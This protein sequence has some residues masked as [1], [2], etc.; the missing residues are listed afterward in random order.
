MNPKPSFETKFEYQIDGNK[1][2][3]SIN[4]ECDQSSSSEKITELN[5]RFINIQNKTLNDLQEKLIGIPITVTCS[6]MQTLPIHDENVGTLAENVNPEIVNSEIVNSENVN[7]ENVV[8]EEED[9]DPEMLRVDELVLQ[10]LAEPDLQT[11]AEHP[12]PQT[13]DELVVTENN[14]DDSRSDITENDGGVNTFWYTGSLTQKPFP[15]HYRRHNLFEETEVLENNNDNDDARSDT[16]E[17]DSTVNTFLYTGSLLTPFPIYFTNNEPAYYDEPLVA[18]A[19]VVAA[20]DGPAILDIDHFEDAPVVT[21]NIDPFEDAPA[22]TNNV[23]HFDDSQYM[24]KNVPFASLNSPKYDTCC[25]RYEAFTG[26]SLVTVLYNCNHIFF[27]DA[28]S[29]WFAASEQRNCPLCR[30]SIY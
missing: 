28:I 13:S 7:P 10:T 19:S 23:D 16:T 20:E 25:I 14:D 12:V 5:S 15:I 8:E 26:E 11:L 2:S 17:I 6:P 1:M 27:A 30:E 3:I 24:L 21:N 29:A 18:A 4:F 22:V 9:N